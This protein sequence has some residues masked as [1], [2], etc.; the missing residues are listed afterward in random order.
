M[1]N[2]RVRGTREAVAGGGGGGG[3][4]GGLLHDRPGQV[5]RGPGRRAYSSREGR[6]CALLFALALGLGDGQCSLLV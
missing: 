1:N 6:L 4:S 2:G 3:G 5:S